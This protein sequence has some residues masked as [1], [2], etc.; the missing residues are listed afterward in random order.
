MTESTLE[1]PAPSVPRSTEYVEGWGMAVGS[2]SP[3][4]RPTSVDEV[5]D[6]FAQARAAGATLGPRGGGNSYGD[7][8][9]NAAGWTLDITRFN[10]L[11]DF[12]AETGRTTAEPGFTIQDLW[13]HGVP[14]GY[15]PKVVSGT[16][17]PT[18]AG[19]AAMNI[20]GK[21]NFAVGTIGDAIT[22]FD[23]ATPAGELLTCNR[24]QHSD[25][26]HAAIGGFGMLGCFTRIQ[27]DTK[28]IHSGELEV[29]AHST[30]N[31]AE[32]MQIIEERKGEADYLVGWIDC[33]PGGKASGRGLI[34]EARYLNEG[35]DPAPEMTLQLEHQELPSK[36]MGV[37]PKSQVWR[38][39]RPFSNDLGM[40]LVNTTKF[41]MGRLEEKKK[42]FRQSHAAFAFLLDY[43]PGWKYAY[44]K[45]GL[46]QYQSFL[47]HETA[48]GAYQEMLELNRR[49]GHVPYLGVFKRHRPDPFWLTHAVDGWSFAMD[50]AVPYDAAGRARLWEHCHRL[51]EV[52]LGAGGKFYFAK[53]LVIEPQHMRRMFEPE[54]LE[55]F[56][57]LKAQHDPEGLLSTNLWR[58]VFGA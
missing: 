8:S 17:F 36:I 7:A 34:H 55:A 29:R 58:R 42:P 11:L 49:A 22:E 33:F 12:D 20:H 18:L 3:V 32:M 50:F 43:V 21:N 16:M 27:L 37:F 40:R 39:L 15:W 45:G 10:Q 53:D 14:R 2:V 54:K 52:V 44:G 31:L 23:I 56:L 25:L 6:C 28:R 19:A 9:V 5:F 1:N 47:P 35:E 4:L 57:G 38:C 26:F 30:A 51:S 13:R 24:E 46:I 48:H 41:H